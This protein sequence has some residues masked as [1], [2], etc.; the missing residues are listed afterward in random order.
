MIFEQTARGVEG[1]AN[2]DMRILMRMVRA[3]VPADHDLAAGD[4]EIDANLEQ[5]ALLMPLVPTFDDDPA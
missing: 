3:G 4:G 5:F 1:V 2:R